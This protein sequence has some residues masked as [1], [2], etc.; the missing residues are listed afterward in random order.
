MN[1]KITDGEPFIAR[2]VIRKLDKDGL[3]YY[4]QIV[5]KRKEIQF[6]EDVLQFLKHQVQALEAV[7]KR[8]EVKIQKKCGN[9]NK[10]RTTMCSTQPY[11]RMSGH[12]T[13]VCRNVIA[14][15]KQNNPCGSNVSATT[16]VKPTTSYSTA[17]NTI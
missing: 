9:T 4:E 16:V 3:R 17:V 13:N 11:C 5:K 14:M 1:V 15:S 7:S 2:I 10:I 8:Q 6:L 12:S